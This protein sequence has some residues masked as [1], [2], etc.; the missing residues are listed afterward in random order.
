MIGKYEDRIFDERTVTFGIGETPDDEIIS[1]IQT[2]LLHFGKGEQSRFVYLEKESNF[3]LKKE[4]ENVIFD[5]WICRLVI[6]SEFAFG[7]TGNESFGVPPNA[8]VEYT[9][10]LQDFERVNFKSQ[11][12]NN[13]RWIKSHFSII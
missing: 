9:V 11:L 2:A 13:K 10:T 12:Y 1:G 3:T 4:D 8:T 6:K 7:E 5:E